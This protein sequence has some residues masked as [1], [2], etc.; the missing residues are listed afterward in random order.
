MVSSGLRCGRARKR[1]IDGSSAVHE[2]SDASQTDFLKIAVRMV[3]PSYTCRN[4]LWR[5]RP[6]REFGPSGRGCEKLHERRV[7][8]RTRIKKLSP[9]IKS[10]IAWIRCLT[11]TGSRAI[12]PEGLQGRSY[13][14]V[15]DTVIGTQ[16]IRCQAA[17]AVIQQ[18]SCAQKT[19]TGFNEMHLGC[20]VCFGRPCAVATHV[21]LARRSC[22]RFYGVFPQAE[23]QRGGVDMR[24]RWNRNLQRVHRAIRGHLNFKSHLFPINVG[25]PV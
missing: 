20:G 5:G 18:C 8:R 13:R 12:E 2:A 19:R 22:A 17:P 23:R 25:A 15:R 24:Y 6:P 10:L 21:N 4:R 11:V 16:E 3:Y 7:R 1:V 14:L 9:T